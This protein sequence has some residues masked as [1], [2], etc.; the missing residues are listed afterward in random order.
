MDRDAQSSHMRNSGTEPDMEINLQ[1]PDA[2]TASRRLSEEL[3]LVR[4]AMEELER[5][6]NVSRETLDS[7]ISV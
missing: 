2:E 1:Q 6:K 7:M 5:A 3:P 4:A